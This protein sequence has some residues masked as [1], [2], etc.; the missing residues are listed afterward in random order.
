MV[1]NY[2]GD[3]GDTALAA[4]GL[5]GTIINLILVLFMG[6]ATGAGIVVAQA[7]GAK[8]AEQLSQSMGTI[9]TLTQLAS[10]V[11]TLLGVLVARPILV[12]MGADGMLLKMSTDYLNVVFIGMVGSAFYNMLSG[13]LRALGDSFTP[14]LFLLVSTVLNIF[15]DIWFV[16]AFAPE[17]AATAV[18]LATIISQTISAVLC[19]LRLLN[20]KHIVTI[21]GRDLRPNVPIMKRVISLGIPA[22][23]TQM[24]FSL[25]NILVQSLTVSLGQNVV[26][27]VTVIMRVDGF[28]MM[29][30]FTY[31]LA[32]T[33]YTGQNVGAKR[34]DRVHQ[35]AKDLLVL[36]VGT[37]VVM[38]IGLLLFGENLMRL[39]TQTEE[40]VTLGAGMLRLMAVGYIAFAV[41]QVLGG[42]MRGA[43]ETVIPMWI[44]IITTVVVR[45]PIAYLWAYFTRSPQYPNGDP[46]CLYA[47]L[48]TAWLFGCLLTI[49]VYRSG[50]WK[51]KLNFDSA[52]E[53]AEPELVNEGSGEA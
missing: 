34:M 12:L 2:C 36:G 31:N 53:P 9:M 14:L 17:D 51:R 52:L 35:G 46:V 40:I 7:F 27:A 11:T 16:I 24:I 1:G 6:I 44:S 33:T 15:L 29:P 4:V 20:M 5:S 47:S 43:G 38:T 3:L 41:S 13:A 39:F 22:G 45:M 23:V 42:V 8:D 19:L 18:A 37:A 21:R 48:L 10:A 26:T 28:A 32:A 49:L 30:N 25:A 50:R